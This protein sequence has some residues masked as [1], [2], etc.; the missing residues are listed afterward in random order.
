[1]N[2]DKLKEILAKLQA[3]CA[4]LS[5]EIEDME[6]DGH[7]DDLLEDEDDEEDA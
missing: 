3:V 5:A 7:L 1:M 4:D 6:L 2:T